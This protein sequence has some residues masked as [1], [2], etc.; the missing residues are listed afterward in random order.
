MSDSG[1]ASLPKLN[2]RQSIQL[3]TA[4]VA[5]GLLSSQ[6]ALK[7][8][9]ARDPPPGPYTT[10]FVESL[11]VYT[12]K[13]PAGLT[14]DSLNPAPTQAPNLR[15]GECGRPTHQRANDWPSQKFYTLTVEEAWHSFHRELPTQKIW[16][17]DGIL[18]GP[19][20]V[21]HYGVPVTVR[22][23]NKLL[24]N[25]VGFGSPE[26]STHLHNQHCGSESDGFTG[27]WYSATKF[28]PTM[29]A[30]GAYKDHH[31]PNCYA[32]YDDPRYQASEGDPREALG[33]LWYHDHRLDFTGPNVYRGL[34]GFYLLFDEIDSGNENDPNRNHPDPAKRALCLPSGVGKCD[35]P[36]VFQ[37]KQFDSSGYLAFD[38]F[39][40]KGILGNKFCVNG[41][42]QP[43][44]SVE[45]RKYRFRLLDGGPSRFYE[46]YLTDGKG[47]NQSFTYI[48]NDGNL[49]PAPLPGVKKV[50]LG[51]AERADIVVD[52]SLYPLGTQL[53]LVNRLIQTDGRGPENASGNIRGAD[54]LLTG[55]GTQILRFDIDSNPPSPDLSQVP[56]ALRE[57]PP[58]N[59]SE[60]KANR[61]FEFDKQNEVWTVNGKIFDVDNAAAKPRRGTAEIWTLKGKGDWHHPVHIHFEEGRILSR[62]GKPPLPHEAGRKDVYVLEPND[63][64]R[65]F[66]RFRE[67]TGKYMM[68]CHNLIHEDHAM[69]IR[70]D[71]VA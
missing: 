69:M 29:T 22:I 34:T 58:I 52:F 48:A 32:G 15:G 12:A 35:I 62:N 54:G 65:V 44:F 45:R 28:G 19:T 61:R 37:D 66:L 50:H 18:P 3:G 25:S 20:F 56:T 24:A 8:A 4:G 71:I 13:T 42:V 6:V 30:P 47:V 23:V 36:L 14:P 1:S 11:P 21:E 26:I 16:G 9:E 55:A 64:V 5:A 7:P 53:Y 51:V 41:K 31:Y 2:R 46:F 63:E 59:L 17:Y 27:D 39:A 70:W 57:L 68:H 33:T 49:L 43:K 40:T 60:V 67:F 10:P 38:Q